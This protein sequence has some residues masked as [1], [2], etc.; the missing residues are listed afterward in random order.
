[1]SYNFPDSFLVHSFCVGL[2]TRPFRT[3]VLGASRQR[4]KQGTKQPVLSIFSFPPS[5]PY[6]CLTFAVACTYICASLTSFLPCVHTNPFL[7]PLLFSSKSTVLCLIRCR[8]ALCFVRQ[9]HPHPLY[10]PTLLFYINFRFV[11]WAE[12]SRGPTCFGL[13]NRPCQKKTPK[14]PLPPP[15]P[16]PLTQAFTQT[17]TL[18]PMLMPTL[19]LHCN[20]DA[21]GEYFCQVVSFLSCVCAF[22]TE[23]SGLFLVDALSCRKDSET[24]QE[25]GTEV[26]EKRPC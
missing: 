15:P 12:V 9:V 26:C 3:P 10:P 14:V 18:N 23:T 1:M 19:V 5:S 6:A 17:Q 7:S 2:C 11:F 13:K 25:D 20:V 22:I 21:S 16:P 24:R 8:F 4:R